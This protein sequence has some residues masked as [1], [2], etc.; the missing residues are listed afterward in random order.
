MGELRCSPLN[1][2]V[3]GLDFAY[4]SGPRLPLVGEREGGAMMSDFEDRFLLH[5]VIANG[6]PLMRHS[7]DFLTL[8]KVV[9][10]PRRP[11]LLVKL[12]ELR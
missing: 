2:D 8:R 10:A 12:D 1:T 3:L 6:L 11:L 5:G 9:L 4:L 7:G